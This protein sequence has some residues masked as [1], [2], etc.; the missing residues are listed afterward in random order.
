MALIGQIAINMKV[1]STKFTKGLGQ[2]TIAV[3]TFQT[4]ALKMASVI[5][6]AFAGL[7]A[8]AGIG[9]LI[10]GGS[11]LIES[12]NAM[13]AVFGKSSQVITDFNKNMAAGFGVSTKEL[14]AS[15]NVFGAMFKN[16][17]YTEQGAAQLSVQMTKLASDVASFKN[18]SFDE[19]L[20]K[21]RSGL[22]GES[23]PLKSIGVN[24][25]EAAVKSEAFAL[26]LAKVGSELTEQQKV[27]S[28]MS[29]ITK[30][31]ADANNDLGKTFTGVANSTK[32]FWGSLENLTDSIGTKLQP[33]AQTVLGEL[34]TAIGAVQMAWDTSGAA[35]LSSAGQVNEAVAS[36]VSSIGFLQGAVGLV[37]DTFH[38]TQIAGVTAFAALQESSSY[39]Y[40]GLGHL[41]SAIDAVGV[42]FGGRASGAD[43]FFK[44]ISDGMHVLAKESMS[45]A[46]S[47][48]FTAPPSA[49]INSFFDDV[50]RKAA[51]ARGDIGALAVNPASIKPGAA[52]AVAKAGKEHLASSAMTFGSS[53]AA[54]TILRSQFGRG[55]ADKSQAETA[56]ATRETANQVKRL[57]DAVTGQKGGGMLVVNDF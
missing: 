24:I 8:G 40:A 46:L 25:N 30:Q 48:A 7:A 27:A 28:R 38:Y 11:D 42:A 14:L 54:N 57:A 4:S 37:A 29:L 5:G 35:A 21:I 18:L 1:D 22:T 50:R 13:Q 6:T 10:E 20:Q 44:T 26:G 9:K 52:S 36:S 31:L 12:Q 56:K 43:K 17:G 34:N 15:E 49:K 16:L 53:D 32:G 23:E 2:A 3:N 51:Q 47:Q 41:V 39:L 55:G 19:A 33:L 45:K